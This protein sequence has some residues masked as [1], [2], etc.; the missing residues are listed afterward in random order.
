M[1]YKLSWLNSGQGDFETWR[2]KARDRVMECLMAPP[3]FIPFDPVVIDS[4]DRGTYIAPKIVFIRFMNI[5]AFAH[6]YK[7]I[8]FTPQAART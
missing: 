7:D 8:T 5:F 6:S 1:G 3:P 2:R 4:E